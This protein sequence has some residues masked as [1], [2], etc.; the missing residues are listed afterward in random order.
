MKRQ[1]AIEIICFLFIILFVY[2]ALMKL[3]DVQ[4]FVVQLN[5]SPLLMVFGAW[6]AW[7]V[8]I[9]EL[10]IAISLIIGRLRLMAL[11]A[12]FTL[13]LIFTLYIIFILTFAPQVPCSCGGILETMGWGEHLM[14]N[15][16]FV[17]LAVV[18]I[19]LLTH[20]REL[21]A[22]PADEPKAILS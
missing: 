11:Y 16:A 20:E 6:A 14:F 7:G 13:M 3:L 15:A 22:S 12:S 19:F 4:K 9:L 21:N 2:A 8:P 18:G 17:A 1:L 5:Q 10:L